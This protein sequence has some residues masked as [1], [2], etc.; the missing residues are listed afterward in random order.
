M[1]EKIVQLN[2]EVIKGQIKE[3]VRGSCRTTIHIGQLKKKAMRNMVSWVI[4]K[5]PYQTSPKGDHIP[6]EQEYNTRH[7]LSAIP[8]EVRREIRR[9]P[10]Q[11]EVQQEPVVHLL[12][13]AALGW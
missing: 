2:E 6:H 13:E 4:V 9:Q 3:L 11:P 7:G 10:R 1:S 12:L 8:N 5:L